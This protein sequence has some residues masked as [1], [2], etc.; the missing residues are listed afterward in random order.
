MRKEE[1]E[2]GAML[3]GF[4][5]FTGQEDQTWTPYKV[6]ELLRGLIKDK[7]LYSVEEVVLQAILQE[8][9]LLN[10]HNRHD[11]FFQNLAK[12]S[13][14]AGGKAAIEEYANSGK[15][16]DQPPELSELVTPAPGEDEEIPTDT[17]FGD[18][19]TQPEEEQ[20][21]PQTVEQILRDTD[22]LE[23]IVDD[24]NSMKFYVQYSINRFWKSAFDD[25][26]NTVKK[27][28]AKGKTSNKFS[29]TVVSTFL[30]EYY[31]TKKL[32]L[33]NEYAFRDQKT[34]K[35]VEP[36][37]MQLY[38]TQKLKQQPGFG[39]FSGT[40]AGKTLS[41]IL[42][43]RILKSKMTLVVCPNDVVKL[44]NEHILEIFP[45][46]T[47]ISR[48]DAFS[49]VYDESKFQYLVINYDKLNQESTP[50]DIIKLI[51]QK[52]DFVILDEIH[53][54]KI[55]S[56]EVGP[57]RHNLDGLLTGIRKK[58]KDARIL[59][60]SATPVVNNLVEG[61]SLLQLIVANREMYDNISTN[62]TT[63]NAVTLF[64]YLTPMS[65]RQIP[66]YKEYDKQYVEVET[67]VPERKT[68]V[69]LHKKPLA[70]EQVLTDARIEEIIKRIDGQTIIYTEYLGSSFP[71][72][73]R[74]IDKIRNAVTEAGFTNDDYTGENHSGLDRFKKKQ[75]QVLIA[76]R[77]I[78]T[79]IDG[80][81]RVCSNLIFN[82]LPWTH[83]LYQQIIGRIVRTGMDESKTVKVH[84]ILAS[85]GGYP[86]DQNKLNRLK[87][88][89]TLADCAVDG[90]LPEKNLVTPAQ[91][92][93]EALKWLARLERGEIS[94][95]TRRQLDVVLSPVEIEKR[96]RTFGDFSKLNRKINTENSK[97]THGRMLKNPDEW[98]EYHRQ[99]REARKTWNVIP[100]EVWIDKIKK[101][102]PNTIVGDFGCG[103]AKIAEAIGNRVKN[104]DHVSID[105][106]VESCD[107]KSVPVESG[108][109]NVAVFSLSLMG[110]DWQ[111][112]LKEAA[113]CL[114]VGGYL[115]ISETT[116]SLTERLEKLRDT[117]QE[118]GF[119]IFSDYEKAQFTFIEARKV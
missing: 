108:T 60:L 14:T 87:Y 85:I 36:F 93:K 18:L 94:C 30:S 109:L 64:K 58:N 47:V 45:D 116:N 6:K 78:S 84:H 62:P 34:N 10:L 75:V 80:L 26:L 31:A 57:R 111:A 5:E 72:E 12:A 50:N 119:K 76:S 7:F 69:E 113:R 98:K 21:I 88:K 67:D 9:G 48:K 79:G 3:H 71:N 49:A 95:V 2:E 74:I 37:L 55:T 23:S 42:A 1:S 39:N 97:T 19:T 73:P 104:F 102:A 52:I 8:K 20:K 40:G 96:I 56:K 24:V 61:K 59:G 35:L 70:I 22:I 83:A 107:M 16:A 29:G 106:N 114:S 118:N 110:K 32:K 28:E 103:E 117:I 44:W 43:T 63:S 99:Y 17:S 105:A 91:A 92:T 77:P 68:L 53:F 82:T 27:L 112:Y 38:I 11:D 90:I 13:K 54:S 66:K 89:R 25:E 41:A 46:S 101:M 4:Y 65:I 86:Y 33:P 100:Y 51:K 81:Q 115:Y 15:N